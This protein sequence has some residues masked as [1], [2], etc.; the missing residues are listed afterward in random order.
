MYHLKDKF[1]AVRR[2]PYSIKCAL[3][4]ST[5]TWNN[6]HANK[7]CRNSLCTCRLGNGEV[8]GCGRGVGGSMPH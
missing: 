2:N 4:R 7:K 5:N 8:N 6:I 3:I 1:D